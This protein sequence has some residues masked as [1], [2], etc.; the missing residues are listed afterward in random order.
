MVVRLANDRA[1]GRCEEC[2][3]L[4]DWR[5]LSGDHKVSRA[6]GGDDSEDNTIVKCGRCHS[7]RHG[8]KEIAC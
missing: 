6:Q 1:Q 2:K 7:L 8:V 5:G 4:P 3:Q